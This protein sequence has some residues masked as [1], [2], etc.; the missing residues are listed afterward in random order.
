MEDDKDV[1]KEAQENSEDI[2]SEAAAGD[3]DEFKCTPCGHGAWM[4]PRTVRSPARPTSKDVEEH[5]LTHCP[6]RAWCDHCVRGQA[7]DDSHSTVKGEFADSTV[8]RVALDYCF[9]QEGVTSKTTEHEDSTRAKTSMTVL[10]MLETLCHS[11]WGYAV[12]PKGASEEWVVEQI[13]EDLETV[14][15]SGEGSL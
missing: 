6:Y 5:D 2:H 10:V 1:S 11:V 12:E 14:G 7:K 13:V 8:V 9:F 15:L 3:G 4:S